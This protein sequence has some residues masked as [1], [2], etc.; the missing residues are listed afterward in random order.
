VSIRIDI[1]GVCVCVCMYT[2]HIYMLHECSHRAGG[3]GVIQRGARVA[4]DSLI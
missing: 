2:V 4:S 1:G 3:E